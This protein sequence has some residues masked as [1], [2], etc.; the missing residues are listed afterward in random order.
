MWGKTVC[1]SPSKQ[2][3][4]A[5]TDNMIEAAQAQVAALIKEAYE[6]AVA[7]GLLPAGG[8]KIPVKVDIPKDAKN[9]DYATSYALAAA[10]ALGKSPRDIAQA[11]MDQMDLEGTYFD[12]STSWTDQ[13]TLVVGKQYKEKVIRRAGKMYYRYG[14][15]EYEVIGIMGYEEESRINQMI[16]MDFRSSLRITGINT[17]YILDTRKEADLTELGQ[18]MYDLF[19]SPAE[20]LIILEQGAKPSVIAGLFSGGAVMRTLYVMTLISFSL[21]TILVTFIWLRFRRQ[22]FFAY[23]LCGYER[24]MERLEI[25]KRFYLAA[26]TGFVAGMLL[27]IFISQFMTDFTM[28]VLDILLT[29]GITIGLGTVILFSCYCINWHKA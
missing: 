15:T 11:L 8:E 6:K 20:M 28:A 4:T 14:G 16:L 10:K 25:S 9:G 19:H 29:L 12:F 22:L 7:G 3:R 5:M 21:S 24:Q 2:R 18:D 13:P 26:G 1:G 23:T 17:E 27:M